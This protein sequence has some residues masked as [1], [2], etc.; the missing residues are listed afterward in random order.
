MTIIIVAASM[1]ISNKERELKMLGLRMML[2][3]VLL[4]ALSTMAITGVKGTLNNAKISRS[5]RIERALQ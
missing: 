1:Y 3:Y 2:A 5:Q 4:I